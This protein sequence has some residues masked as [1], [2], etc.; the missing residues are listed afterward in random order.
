MKPV[1]QKKVRVNAR[2]LYIFALPALVVFLLVLI[3]GVVLWWPIALLSLP[4][5]AAVV[6]VMWNRSDQV[7][8]SALG[9]RGLGQTEG[10]R[11]LNTVE[12]LSLSSGIPQPNVMAIDDQAC[13]IAVVSGREDTIVVT[14]GI[15]ETLDL[16]EMEGV[17]A[18]VLTKVAAGR[19]RYATLAA[20]AR[21]FITSGQVKQASR[22]G[23]DEGGIESFDISGV[24]LTRYPPGLLSALI[25]ID[26]RSTDIAGGDS[27]GDAWFVP[28]SSS[29][30][31]L[32]TRIEVLQEL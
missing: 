13:N 14:T 15:L 3:A 23:S 2:V 4:L 29:G 26:G 17:I 8:L 6:W 25:R 31:Q 21:P 32:G 24:G 22:W 1:P 10:Q 20:S 9:A 28:P 30:S 5:A 19:A 11:V 7:V 12:S 16:M 18:H 27:L